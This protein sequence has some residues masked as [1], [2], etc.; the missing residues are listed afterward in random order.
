MQTI[1][2]HEPILITG[3]TGFAGSHL[4]EALV[5]NGYTNLHL[6]T[7]SNP[8]E[9]VED[10]FALAQLH[11]LDLTEY[12]QTVECIKNVNPRW[13]FHLASTSVVENSFKDKQK[14][15]FNNIQLQENLL[16]AIH[17]HASTART[18]IIS[19]AEVYGKSFNE[20]ELP[21]NETH[22]FRPMNPYA[23]S[24][25]YQDSLAYMYHLAFGLDI[26]R[27]R[28]FNHIGERQSPQF[29]VSSFAQQVVKI[30]KG[31][32]DEL[33][34]GNTDSIRDFTDVKDM[35]EAYITV[36]Q[37]GLAGE[38]YNIGSGKGLT[39]KEII[40]MLQELTETNVPIAVDSDRLRPSDIPV[41]I[42]DIKKVTEL[43]WQ[44][45]IPIQDT[46]KRILEDW[47]EKL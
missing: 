32:Q 46:L 2:L 26:I 28:P 31:L 39:V 25:I 40:T 30:E 45:S 42:A 20:S 41:M 33:S 21:I 7:Q 38:V 29:V 19:S 17:L 11:V 14:I 35:V 9:K 24:K 1:Q 10:F 22:T 13:I 8:S 27:V 36:M 15:Q 4:Y 34:V 44:P 43:G 37:K 47:R 5:R 23:V 6:T 3:G 16:E 18:L 12:S